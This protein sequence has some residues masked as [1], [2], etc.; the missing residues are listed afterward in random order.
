MHRP[1]SFVVS[2]FALPSLL[3]GATDFLNAVPENAAMVIQ[4]TDSVEMG[5]RWERS[6]LRTAFQELDLPSVLNSLMEIGELNEDEEEPVSSEDLEK[7]SSRFKELSGYLEGSSC[8]Y[9]GDLRE[10]FA[11]QAK[12]KTKRIELFGEAPQDKAEEAF[13]EMTEDARTALALDREEMLA[14]SSGFR[15]MADLRDSGDELLTKLEA[16]TKE[17]I[18]EEKDN[19]VQTALERIEIDGLTVYHEKFVQKDEDGKSVPSIEPEAFWTVKNSVLVLT[20]GE[21]AMRDQLELLDRGAEN[22]LQDN[23]SFQDAHDHTESGDL[24]FMINPAVLHDWFLSMIPQNAPATPG[25][26]S[27]QLILDWLALKTFQPYVF[28]FALSDEGL[29]TKGQFG[30]SKPSVFSDLFMQQHD[31]NA[32]EPVF[33]HRDFLSVSSGQFSLGT[34]YES[35]EKHLGALSP[36]AA[37]GLGMARM[38]AAGQLGLDFKAQLLDLLG[39]DLVFVQDVD[40]EKLKDAMNKA[41][42]DPS[43]PQA[44][45]DNPFEQGQY[46]LIGMAVN[47]EATLSSSLNTLLAKV[48]PQGAPEPI[49][50]KGHEIQTPLKGLNP[51]AGEAFSDLF[52]YAMIDDYL[53]VSLGNPELLRRA[54]DAKMD[55]SL[56]L[57]DT[58]RFQDVRTIIPGEG[59]W[60]EF[61]NQEKISTMFDSMFAPLQTLLQAEGITLPDFSMFK[62]LFSSSLGVSKTEG[63]SIKVESITLFN[64]DDQ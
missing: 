61:T 42:E 21:A 49:E 12:N 55:K 18:Q 54:I 17:D 31:G 8:F 36:Q 4:V 44:A 32:P 13:E 3:F 26:P 62:N 2:F 5:A 16:W 52:T 39:S 28:S 23:S 53:V 58:D 38:M 20:F 1:F 45:K 30:F 60:V 37:A 46:Y 63:L 7:I 19:N 22:S 43:T 64:Q 24:L 47:D 50:Y 27:P 40:F 48:H 10:G 33:I 35:L 14:F 29:R 34:F 51:S 25:Q 41:I 6:P 59:D 15:F 56:R 9:I 57:W 11:V